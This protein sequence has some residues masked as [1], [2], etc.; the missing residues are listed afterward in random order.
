VN[1]RRKFWIAIVALVA[2][3]GVLVVLITPAPD[4]LPSTGPHSLNKTFPLV[5]SHFSPPSLEILSG[6]RLQFSLITPLSREN[7]LSFTCA[8]L[9]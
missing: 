3:I 5:S 7:L 9:C 4:E 8:R 2:A 1:E 6:L